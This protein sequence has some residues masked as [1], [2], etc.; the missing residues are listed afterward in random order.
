[1]SHNAQLVPSA[2]QMLGATRESIADAEVAPG[3][4]TDTARTL[5]SDCGRV[6]GNSSLIRSRKSSPPRGNDL[7]KSIVN[8]V[9]SLPES[10]SD[11][12]GCALN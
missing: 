10:W 9:T 11:T 7:C 8:P 2:N 6:V 5:A 1:M 3:V 12:D 4:L